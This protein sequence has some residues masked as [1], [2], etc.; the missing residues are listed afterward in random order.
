MG[1][2]RAVG[3]VRLDAASPDPAYRAGMRAAFYGDVDPATADAAIAL[4]APDAP[5][6]I[7]AGATTL[8]AG[9]W[10]SIPRTYVVCT[11]DMT[12]RPALQR[13]FIA[14]ADAAFPANPTAVRELEA[15]HSPFLSMPAQVADIVLD[16][17]S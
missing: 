7:S 6:G 5:S 17:I 12:I 3:A 13:K 2:P 16:V 4:L 9:C 11:Q 10:G 14:D 8:T 1:S 15:S